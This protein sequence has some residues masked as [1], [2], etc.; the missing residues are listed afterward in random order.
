MSDYDIILDF[1]ELNK[2]DIIAALEFLAHRQHK[3]L[4]AA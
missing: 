1:P 2:E 4:I 3:T